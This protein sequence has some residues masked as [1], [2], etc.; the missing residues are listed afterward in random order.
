MIYMMMIDELIMILLFNNY[1]ILFD[2][3]ILRKR[4]V[5]DFLLIIIKIEIIFI[6]I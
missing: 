2:L 6:K 3:G 5:A 1:M 4:L